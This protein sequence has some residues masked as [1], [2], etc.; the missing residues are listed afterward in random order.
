MPSGVYKRTEEHKRKMSLAQKERYKDE[1]ER[2]KT[3]LAMKGRNLS[4][5]HR[6]NISERMKREWKEGKRKPLMLG[7]HH[8]EETRRKISQSQIGKKLSKETRKKIS[9]AFKGPRHPLWGK[10]HTEE[11]KNKMRDTK[12]N[13]YR[14]N[15]ELIIRI[16]NSVKKLWQDPEYRKEHTGPNHHWWKGGITKR[17]ETLAHALRVELRN[18]AK[19]VLERGNYTCQRCGIR[20]EEKRIMQVHHIKSVLEYPSLVLDIANG[21]TLCKNCHRKTESYGRKLRKQIVETSD[22]IRRY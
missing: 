17:E 6:K 11:T 13:Q 5:E 8:S 16:S 12:I 21:I 9:E 14:N 19:K 4:E 10:R 2:E 1:K 15:S 22:V 18:W 7:N 20:S 3:S